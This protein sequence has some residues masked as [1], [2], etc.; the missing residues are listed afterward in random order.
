[1]I[2]DH[3]QA[4]DDSGQPGRRHQLLAHRGDV[5]GKVVTVRLGLTVHARPGRA[6]HMLHVML[7]TGGSGGAA[8]G[9]VTA[10]LMSSLGTDG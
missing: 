7:R 2:R 4:A 9:I 3:G 5:A 1:V 10:W 8:C 6:Q